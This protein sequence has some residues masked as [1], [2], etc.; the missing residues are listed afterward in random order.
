[1][2]VG[3]DDAGTPRPTH[4]QGLGQRRENPVQCA[5][6]GTGKVQSETIMLSDPLGSS[7]QT[8]H[9][10]DVDCRDHASFDADF[11]LI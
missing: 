10:I 1:M 9:Q 6:C 3:H 11:Y 7:R 8:S 4:V 5:P 2:V